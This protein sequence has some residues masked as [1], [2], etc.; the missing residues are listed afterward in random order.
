M[1]RLAFLL[2]C[3][4]SFGVFAKNDKLDT[5][6]LFYPGLPE[7]SADSIAKV[8]TAYLPKLKLNEVT[9]IKTVFGWKL[10][11]Q[12]SFTYQTKDYLET[13][14]VHNDSL[15][16][17]NVAPGV[18][19]SLVLLA[20]NNPGILIIASRQTTASYGD[21][22]W[23][24]LKK[25]EIVQRI[26]CDLN[27]KTVSWATPVK[28]VI[29]DLVDWRLP[30]LGA[31]IFLFGLYLL[32][33]S[34]KGVYP[35]LTRKICHSVLF[36]SILSVVAIMIMAAKIHIKDSDILFVI[37]YV[38]SIFCCGGGL[39][40]SFRAFRISSIFSALGAI[41]GAVLLVEVLTQSWVAAMYY[42][43]IF[44]AVYISVG[45]LICLMEIIPKFITKKVHKKKGP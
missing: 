15:G 42:L 33:I 16:M 25:E 24:Q 45:T 4:L 30:A 6:K 35:R 18:P 39:I 23:F 40:L 43:L 37:L 31:L 10:V 29:R 34:I 27:K 2:S 44:P 1:Y 14:D 20:V 26:V 17:L 19:D 21:F 8:K 32:I 36:F 28:T 7:A 9:A 5:T 41:F 22:G 13:T 3:L 12:T 11:R 38:L